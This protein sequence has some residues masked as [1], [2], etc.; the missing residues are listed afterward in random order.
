MRA[1][2]RRD[3]DFVALDADG[4]GAV[5]EKPAERSLGLEA[6]QQ[7]GGPGCSTASS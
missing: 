1:D 5:V 2:A 3:L 4:L 7:H 6:D